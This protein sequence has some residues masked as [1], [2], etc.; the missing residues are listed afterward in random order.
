[1]AKGT[2]SFQEYNQLMKD[3]TAGSV[4]PVYLLH[5]EEYY[6]LE[7]ILDQIEKSSVDEA[8]ASFNHHVFYGKDANV[9]DI[10]NTARRF[11]MMADRQL[12]VVKEAQHLKQAEQIISYLESPVPSTVLVW[13][14]PGKKLPTNRKPGTAFKKHHVF[15]AEPLKEQEVPDVIAKYVNSK[16]YD[17]EP[18]SLHM[19]VDYSSAKL[20][21]IVKEL[22]KVFANLDPGSK[23]RESH[24]EE[25]VGINK[26]YNIF[27]LQSALAKREQNKVLEILNYMCGNMGANPFPMLLATLFSYFRKVAIMQSMRGKTDKEVMAAL[28]IPFYFISEY[29]NAAR[30]YNQVQIQKVIEI[31]HEGDLKFKGIMENTGDDTALLRETILRILSA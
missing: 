18:K 30:S 11:P 17:I 9:A 13:Y 2:S 4:Q 16:G 29:R 14:H 8:T 7:N 15:N 20:S 1:M 24:I 12:V 25:F 31:I 10:V 6:F 26:E 22:D 21:V 5:G 3:L 28:G 27:S 19:L 23:I